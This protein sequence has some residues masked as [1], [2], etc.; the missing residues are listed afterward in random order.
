MALDITVFPH[1]S[2]RIVVVDAPQTEA[3]IQNIVD[4]IRAWEDSEEGHTFP[5]II[6]AAG[7]ENLG[8][9]VTVGITATLNNAQLR[10][11]ARP[12]P[13]TT[14]TIT[15]ANPLGQYLI[16]STADFIADGIYVGATVFN[17]T[18]GAME[19]IIGIDS[20]SLFSFTLQ[21][22]SRTD[23]QVGDKYYVY[24][25]DQCSISG[26][27]LVAV[28]SYKNTISPVLQSPNTH[29]VRSSSSSATL[30]QL[31]AIQYSSY[32]NEVSL[33]IIYGQ[34][35][36]AY[37]IG[38]QEFPVNNLA[39][40]V[41]I[42]NTKGFKTISIRESMTIHT[43]T[44]ITNFTIKGRSH[45]STSVVINPL[46]VCPGL[47]I[48]NCNISGTLDG[49]TNIKDCNVGLINY[50]N[51]HIHKSGLYG[52][53]LLDGNKDA[54]IESC[55]T[56]DQ[57]NPVRIDMGGSGQDLAMPNYSGIVYVE[58]FNDST[59]EIGIGIDGG[60]V[61][62]ENTITAGTIIISGSGIL[63]DNSTGSANVNSDSLMNNTNIANAVV[64]T[65]EIQSID[66]KT[67]LIPGLF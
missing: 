6:D 28:D 26:G 2:P 45:V 60:M 22:G 67:K 55:Y 64:K 25:N 20:T 16:D 53:I 66:K 62:L 54:V 14:G 57:D 11:S 47:S 39:D 38:N 41:Y 35:G 43:S 51:G 17:Y 4:A 46:S 30:A 10:F 12:T 52:T 36:T 9:G 40:A 37:P 59:G 50:V 31:D 56:V 58:N 44:D 23:W 27:N 24:P 19:T 32:G 21:A 42:A 8:G 7:K 61:I 34:S 63:I 3:T 18:T 5:F 1:L 48:E 29:I 65:D 33:D 49:G 13:M 15:T